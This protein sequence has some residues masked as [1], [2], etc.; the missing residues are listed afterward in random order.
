MIVVRHSLVDE[1]AKMGFIRMLPRLT[2]L[3]VVLCFELALI[4]PR[5]IVCG[6]AI[7][8]RPMSAF[9]CRDIIGVDLLSVR[10]TKR[11]L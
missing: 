9:I 6:W 11:L 2:S 8:G 7:S 10:K 4:V 3:I 5:S 1:V